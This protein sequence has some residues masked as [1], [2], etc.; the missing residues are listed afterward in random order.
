MALRTVNDIIYAHNQARDLINLVIAYLRLWREY[1]NGCYKVSVDSDRFTVVIQP[2][3]SDAVLRVGIVYTKTQ[4]WEEPEYYDV[5]DDNHVESYSSRAN[6]CGYRSHSE[7]VTCEKYFTIPVK[8]LLLNQTDMIKLI[9][10]FAVKAKTEEAEALRLSK[11]AALES[12][13]EKL[14]SGAAK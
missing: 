3:T 1:A 2:M 10:D 9:K 13:L 4:T 8:H 7:D 14:K 5:D 11:I 6:I 12:Q